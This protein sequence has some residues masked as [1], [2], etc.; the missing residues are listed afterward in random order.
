ML[1]SGGR[2]IVFSALILDKSS[3]EIETQ[4]K[5]KFSYKNFNFLTFFKRIIF[6]T[7]KRA[8]AHFTNFKLI[9]LIYEFIKSY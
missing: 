5:C 6:Q 7:G 4:V 2:E 9:Q 1:P 8:P 3:N